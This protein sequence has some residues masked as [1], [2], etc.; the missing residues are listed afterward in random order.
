[1]RVRQ[2]F[3]NDVPI[4]ATVANS[5]RDFRYSEDKRMVAKKLIRVDLSW[6]NVL[7]VDDMQTNLDVIAGLLSKYKMRVDCVTSGR[8]AIEKMRGEKPVYNAIFMDHMMPGMTGIEA[9][10]AIRALGTEYSKNIPMI[11]LTANAVQ[12]AE[13]MF[14][15]HGFQDFVSKPIDVILLDSVIRKWIHRKMPEKTL[16]VKSAELE[17]G[18][19]IEIP[20]VDAEKGLSYYEGERD[21]YLIALRSYANNTPAVL[22]KIRTVSAETLADYAVLV[23]GLK[24]TSS[25]IGAEKTREAAAE[26]E[27]M[28]KNGDLT[29]VLAKNEDF[30]EYAGNVAAGIEDWLKK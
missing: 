4:G 28:A 21:I 27:A 20:G 12:G 18:E 5:L 2:G 15:E 16:D 7:V 3:V 25:F 14:R 24:G 6:A 19:R 9:S 23:H 26:L 22:D 29:G 8:E 13:E 10:D 30:I 11:V 17:E 1:V